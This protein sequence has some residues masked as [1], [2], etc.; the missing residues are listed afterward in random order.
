MTDAK[1][2]LIIAKTILLAQG[3]VIICREAR[4]QNIR[5]KAL[6]AYVERRKPKPCTRTILTSTM[7]LWSGMKL[8]SGLSMQLISG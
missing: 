8:M 7:S 2:E 4:K 1:N 3:K 5:E 6:M